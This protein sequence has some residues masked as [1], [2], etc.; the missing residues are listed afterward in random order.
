[1]KGF[2]I[3]FQDEPAVGYC[4]G[5]NEGDAVRIAVHLTGK[6]VAKVDTLPYP[7]RPI[8]WQFVHPVDGACPAFCHHPSKCKGHTACP[9]NP[10]CTS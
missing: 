6:K 2:W 1:M 9:T 4:E 5:A 10:S 8:I 3:T 7:A